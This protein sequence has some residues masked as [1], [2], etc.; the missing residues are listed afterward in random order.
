MVNHVKQDTYEKVTVAEYNYISSI[1]WKI[2]RNHI[3]IHACMH[4]YIYTYIYTYS[5]SNIKYMQCC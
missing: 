5:D 3:N 2:T 1:V 4:A